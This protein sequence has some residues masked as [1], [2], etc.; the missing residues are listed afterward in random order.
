MAL[1]ASR[2]GPHQASIVALPVVVP[3]QGRLARQ[4]SIGGRQESRLPLAANGSYF[5]DCSAN[6]VIV[7][8]FRLPSRHAAGISYA[9][10]QTCVRSMQL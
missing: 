8:D 7:T 10:E 6:P 1:A 2:P 3:G 4:I 9:E 5:I